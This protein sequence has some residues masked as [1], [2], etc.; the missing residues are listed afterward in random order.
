MGE[1]RRMSLKKKIILWFNL[2]LFVVTVLVSVN[3]YHSSKK[4]VI[5]SIGSQAKLIVKRT[6]HVVSIPALQK[7]ITT[8]EIGQKR[9]A[10][11]IEKEQDYQNMR[12]TLQEIKE[13]NGLKYLYTMAQKKDGS[14]IY[15]VDGA[16][17]TQTEDVS[18]PGDTEENDYRDMKEA[19]RTK[20]MQI[21]ELT[22][23]EEYGANVTTYVPL[24]DKEN[25]FVGVMGADFD[26]TDIY[27]LMNRTKRFIILLTVSALICS[28]VITTFIAKSLTYPLQ[29]LSETME[30]VREGDLTVSV[31]SYKGKEVERLSRSIGKMLDYLHHM[32]AS[33]KKGSTELDRVTHQL[34]EGSE[35]L[36]KKSGY[37]AQDTEVLVKQT[38]ERSELIDTS[39]EHIEH[40]QSQIQEIHTYCESV[41]QSGDE[42]VGFAVKGKE[43]IKEVVDTMNDMHHYQVSSS[44]QMKELEQKS[45]EI[46]S[47][48]D[49]IT[50]I[51]N[52]TNLLALNASIEAARAG[53]HGRG[54]KVVAEEVKKLAQQS[55]LSI[56]TIET[57]IEDIQKM[58]G[59]TVSDAE[60][61]QHM[62]ERNA[63]RMEHSASNF[64]SIIES[65]EQVNDSITSI[66]DSTKYLVETSKVTKQDIQYAKEVAMQTLVW[67]QAFSSLIHEQETVA[68]EVIHMTTY[69]TQTSQ[70]L[71]QLVSAFQTKKDT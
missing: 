55:S 42:V 14:Y 6:E 56:S 35:Q 5:E 25:K 24:F 41:K 48:L 33:I 1:V 39:L 57:Y 40:I 23:D 19:F 27:Q 67:V 54:F 32:I 16:P 69:V 37:I 20:R 13:Q 22:K 36:T 8:L 63:N 38:L 43:Y 29:Q 15:V 45:K 50:M 66:Y 34:Y 71:L 44:Q 62:M 46:H 65:V 28:M 51:A 30:V 18:L 64:L 49:V 7:M 21:G 3:I 26:A 17:L 70:E 2:V 61:F 59:R 52:Q 9:K 60:Q 58:V 31:S 10:K 47:I 11:Q 4:M 12:K 53:E 68:E